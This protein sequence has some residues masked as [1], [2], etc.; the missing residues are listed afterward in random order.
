LWQDEDHDVVLVL[1]R[2][3]DD[4][5]TGWSL[6]VSAGQSFTLKELDA[7]LTLGIVPGPEELPREGDRVEL[8]PPLRLEVQDVDQDQAG[9]GVDALCGNMIAK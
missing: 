7:D 4:L 9:V 5:G 6:V 2:Q 3:A 1:E 8:G